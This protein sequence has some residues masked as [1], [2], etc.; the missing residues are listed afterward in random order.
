MPSR[1]AAVLVFCLGAWAQSGA[2]TVNKLR[3]F[4]NSAMQQKMS[5]QEVARYLRTVKLS[6]RLDDRTIEDLQ[7]KGLGPKTVAVLHNLRDATASLKVAQ[8]EP[9]PPPPPPQ[10]PPPSAEEQARIIEEARENSLNYSNSLPNYLCLQVTR[11][12][13]NPYGHEDSWIGAGTI[14]ER[15]SYVDHHEE[16]KTV[17]VNDQVSNVAAE[18]LG[19]SLSRG[20]FGT[21]LRQIFERRS[22]T[23]FEWERWT[24]LHG[25]WTYVFHFRVPLETSEYRIS[26]GHDRAGEQVI[27]VGYSGSIFV[28]KETNM[29]SRLKFQADNIPAGFPVQAASEQLDY[30]Y[31]KI[32]DQEFLLPLLAEMRGK[33]DGK[34]MYR[35]TIEFRLYNKFSAD[36]VIRFDE[37][38]PSTPAPLSD[39]K[40]KE[41][42]P[43]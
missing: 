6:E 12:Y 21:M 22:R 17:T 38:P 8:P 28:D 11:R 30:D 29:V 15:L 24:G 13:F 26:Y 33:V 41:K 40:T 16:Y 20:E 39:D 42:P 3:E 1:V 10:K 7:G 18:K 19:G 27:T 36:A 31:Q 43:K 37:T 23:Q 32:G 5:D 35:N 14:T 9:P 25:R 34:I 4:L 2:L